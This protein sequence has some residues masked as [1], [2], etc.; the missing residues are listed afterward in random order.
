MLRYGLVV[1]A[2]ILSVTDAITCYSCSQYTLDQKCTSIS[3]CTRSSENSCYVSKQRHSD[4]SFYFQSGCAIADPNSCT[5]EQAGCQIADP[6]TDVQCC[7]DND[8]NR[9]WQS[10]D[11]SEDEVNKE[12]Y[13]VD[14]NNDGETDKQEE[15]VPNPSGS[16][17][18]ENEDAQPIEGAV[19][20][21]ENSFSRLTL[22]SILFSST[23][24]V[25]LL[26]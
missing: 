14:G 20:D 10:A 17:L 3:E 2:T 5:C 6:T 12:D 21:K 8:C 4:G 25:F 19:K 7:P 23:L 18:S 22:S 9:A 13:D 11:N 26:R 1:L 24:G 16:D 15:D